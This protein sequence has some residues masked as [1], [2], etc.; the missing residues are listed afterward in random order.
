MFELQPEL[1]IAIKSLMR[2]IRRLNHSKNFMV[3]DEKRFKIFS[4][5]TEIKEKQKLNRF[6][7]ENCH[8][9]G[10][11]ILRPGFLFHCSGTSGCSGRIATPAQSFPILAKLKN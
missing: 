3:L 11:V 9:N 6:D 2:Q 8:K 1:E 5:F 10:Q 4:S 7:L